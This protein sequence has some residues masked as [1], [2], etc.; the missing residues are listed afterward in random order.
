MEVQKIALP[1]VMKAEVMHNL[2]RVSLPK[3]PNFGS[4]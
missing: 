4:S 2:K 3:F 1:M